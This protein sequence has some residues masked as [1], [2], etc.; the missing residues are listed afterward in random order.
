MGEEGTTPPDLSPSGPFINPI[1]Q[2][3]ARQTRR[4]QMNNLLQGWLSEVDSKEQSE[5]IDSNDDGMEEFSIIKYKQI[6]RKAVEATSPNAL[7]A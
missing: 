1:S 7:L 4:A 3:I 2:M 5:D 6:L